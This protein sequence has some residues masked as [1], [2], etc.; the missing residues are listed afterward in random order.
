MIAR[1]SIIAAVAGLALAAAAPSQ[2]T[3]P[4]PI[5]VMA[6]ERET[7]RRRRA[8]ARGSLYKPA[9]SRNKPPKR[10]LKPN[11]NHIGKRARRKH[12]RAGK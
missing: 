3:Q 12:R 8:V 2:V 11:R 10:K 1:R 7:Q 6:E 9:R 4:A 5:E